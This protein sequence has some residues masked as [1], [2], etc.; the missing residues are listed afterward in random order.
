[1]ES[2][3]NLVRPL[4]IERLGFNPRG[5]AAAPNRRRFYLRRRSARLA[6]ALLGPK[7]GLCRGQ[8]G[9]GLGGGGLAR[10]NTPASGVLGSRRTYWPRQL[11][12]KDEKGVL[13]LTIARN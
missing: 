6:G 5:E 2:G 11:V 3:S 13:M 1:M 4:W 10:Q 9:A 7:A 12:K 8:G